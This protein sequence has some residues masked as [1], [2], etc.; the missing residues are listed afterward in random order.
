MDGDDG[1]LGFYDAKQ[2]S[3]DNFLSGLCEVVYEI[4]LDAWPTDVR[5]KAEAARAWSGRAE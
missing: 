3:F 4:N 5:R 1:L 2:A